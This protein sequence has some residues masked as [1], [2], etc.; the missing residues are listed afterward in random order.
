MWL[1]SQRP[2]LHDIAR[3]DEARDE[4]RARAVVD[5]L[6]RARPARSCRRSSRRSGRRWSSPRTGRASRR[7]SC[8]G[9][10]R[11]GGAPRS[12]SPRAG[13][14]RGS[15]A[16]RR[17]AAS[18]ARRSARARAR[19]A[20]AARR[21]ARPDSARRSASSL[22]TPRMARDLLGD[23]RL[24]ELAQR[25]P[26]GD[27]LRHRHVRP[28]R[29]A[30]EDHRHVALLGRQRARRR[31]HHA[32]ADRDL[33]RRRLD[34]ARRSAAGSWSCRSRKARAGRPAARARC[35]ATHRRRPPDRRSA[36][37]IRAAQPTPHPLRT[38]YLLLR[39]CPV[40]SPYCCSRASSFDASTASTAT[41]WPAAF[42]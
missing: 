5:L 17:A 34:E 30:L 31:G 21:R 22:V 24:V 8:S 29:V 25:Q 39:L 20:A 3:P 23:H 13:W 19:R 4:F 41:S 16:A 37:S 14:R 38:G 18:P 36:W 33:A 10:R 35:A 32:V 1:A 27:V 15:T 42:Q 2:A 7:P 28:E 6:R 26:V 9:I 11:A 40:F 12:A